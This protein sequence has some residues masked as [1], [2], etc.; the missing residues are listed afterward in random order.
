MQSRPA[1]SMTASAFYVLL[2]LSQGSR[3]GREILEDVALSSAGR[4]SL[5]QAA[6]HAALARLMRIGLIE[7]IGGRYRLTRHGR[8]ELAGEL[9]RIDHA[10]RVT[11]TRRQA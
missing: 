7:A 8:A 2:A 1:A 6:F 4:L 5:G 10:L 3:G 11:R 9:Q